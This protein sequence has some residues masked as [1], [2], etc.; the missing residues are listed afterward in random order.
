MHDSSTPFAAA[1][2]ART[3]PQGPV[4]RPIRGPPAAADSP[5]TALR[6]AEDHDRIAERLGDVVVRRIFSAG[7]DLDAAL[8]L[9]GEHRAAA[10]V[11]HAISEL[12]LAVRDI[13]DIRDTVFA[14]QRPDSGAADDPGHQDSSDAMTPPLPSRRLPRLRDG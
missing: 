13:R 8:G 12:D 5:E 1:A 11:Q 6:L 4:V 2:A 9:I 14:P 3:L 7:L 10:K